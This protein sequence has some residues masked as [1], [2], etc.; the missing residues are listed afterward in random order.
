MP[1]FFEV[2]PIS[3]KSLGIFVSDVVGHGLQA[4]LVTAV[5]RTLIEELKE[6]AGDAE[7][8]LQNVNDRLHRI[9]RQTT[10][11]VYATAFYL[12]LDMDAKH[13]S[14]CNA[15]HPPQLHLRRKLGEIVRLFDVSKTGPI[16]GF[17]E[18]A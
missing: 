18:D 6:E 2:L 5:L 1:D 17:E 7:G 9:L 13:G 15:G 12:K 14:F 16:L 3:D 4:A 8:L 10:T 11:P